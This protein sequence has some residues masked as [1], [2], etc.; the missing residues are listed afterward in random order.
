MTQQNACFNYHP[1]IHAF[2]PC[3]IEDFST[4]CMCGK[5]RKQKLLSPLSSGTK[6]YTKFL[7]L[8]ARSVIYKIKS[9]FPQ[10]VQGVWHTTL[11]HFY[12]D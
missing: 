7:Q 5:L 1:L 8:N 2:L 4:K 9:Y 12:E 3:S 10:P 11:L 6:S